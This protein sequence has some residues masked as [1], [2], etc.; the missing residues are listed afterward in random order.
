V[1]HVKTSAELMQVRFIGVSIKTIE[2]LGA[3]IKQVDL[4]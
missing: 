2:I 4:C 1:V 3:S